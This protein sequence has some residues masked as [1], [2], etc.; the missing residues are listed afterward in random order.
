MS[1][2]E[3]ADRI[4]ALPAPGRAQVER[5]VERLSR[6][7]PSGTSDDQVSAKAQKIRERIF[8]KHG[9]LGDSAEEIRQFR[10]EGR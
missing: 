9:F 3:L 7:L 8:R 4:A 5:F 10:E 2:T 1:T 6:L